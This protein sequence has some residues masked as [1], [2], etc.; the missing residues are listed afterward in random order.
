MCCLWIKAFPL[1]SKAIAAGPEEQHC[2]RWASLQIASHEIVVQTNVSYG[3]GMNSYFP[4]TADLWS[5]SCW[6]P[7]AAMLSPLPWIKHLWLSIRGMLAALLPL[8]AAEVSSA[9]PSLFVEGACFSW[10]ILNQARRELRLWMQ[11]WFYPKASW[12]L[13]PSLC[14]LSILETGASELG[15]AC[16]PLH[17]DESPP[18]PTCYP[19]RG[20]A[21]AIREEE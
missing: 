12:S 19:Y 8:L 13:Q 15:H 1:P 9:P 4:R 18:C 7:H 21:E 20:P 11:I 10:A 14:S 16:K 2:H 3:W 17:W 5:C 6:C